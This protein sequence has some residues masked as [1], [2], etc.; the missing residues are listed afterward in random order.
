M[1]LSAGRGQARRGWHGCLPAFSCCYACCFGLGD[2]RPP[3]SRRRGPSRTPT[4]ASSSATATGRRSPTS[5]SRRS[6][7]GGRRPGRH[8]LANLAGGHFNAS[9]TIPVHGADPWV[10]VETPTRHHPRRRGRPIPRRLLLV[11]S[12]RVRISSTVAG[13][14]LRWLGSHARGDPQKRRR[15]HA[16]TRRGFFRNPR[17]FCAPTST[18]KEEPGRC[19][20]AKPL[21][22]DEARRIAAN[23]AKLPEPLRGPLPTSEARR[24]AAAHSRCPRYVGLCFNCGRIA[25]T[26]RRFGPNNGREQSQQ[27]GCYS[28]TSSASA[29]NVGGNREAKRPGCFDH[30]LAFCGVNNAPIP[31]CALEGSLIVFSPCPG[32]TVSRFAITLKG[33]WAVR[34]RQGHR[35]RDR[36]RRSGRSAQ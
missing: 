2:D 27:N 15:Q 19:A 21:T 33:H 3:L 22:R 24:V 34:H 29:S 5:I 4:P 13:A 35:R 9:S 6:R 32:R 23:I 17:L 1:P 25:A 11:W 30:K 31:E 18:S 10:I 26:R 7:D 12:E 14:H 8:V 36:R 28:I 20:A 16:R